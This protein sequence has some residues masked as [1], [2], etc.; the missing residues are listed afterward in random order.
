[1]ATLSDGR[2]V[3]NRTLL[4]ALA[5][6]DAE[7]KQ[8]FLDRLSRTKPKAGTPAAIEAKLDALIELLSKDLD[9]E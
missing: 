5:K 7:H 8:S 1:M 9:K 2:K 6:A 3:D 4:A